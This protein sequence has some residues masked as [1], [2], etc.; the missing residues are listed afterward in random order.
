MW[1]KSA[2]SSLFS[3]AMRPSSAGNLLTAVNLAP[4]TNHINFYTFRPMND[5][6]V[7]QE[8]V[9]AARNKVLW[10]KKERTLPSCKR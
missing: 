1:I 3:F 2:G 8:L 9:T 4:R 5:S 10:L 6:S 7:G